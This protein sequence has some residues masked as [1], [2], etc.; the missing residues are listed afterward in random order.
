M[1]L[2]ASLI[3]IGN[4]VMIGPNVT[5]I[6]QT[7]DVATG[8]R[9]MFALPVTIEDDCWLGA[10]C[11]VLP[12]VTLGKG[13]NIGAGAVV[14]RDIPAATLAVGVPAK[15]IRRLSEDGDH[16]EGTNDET[17]DDGAGKHAAGSRGVEEPVPF[18]GDT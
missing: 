9:C 18:A 14:A 4:R 3:T 11:T 8:S 1:A 5:I 17:H 12:G 2:D 16:V 7:H 15:V 10:G 13:C 6:T